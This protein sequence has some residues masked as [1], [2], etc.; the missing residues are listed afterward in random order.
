MA[1]TIIYYSVFPENDNIQKEPVFILKAYHKNNQYN[2]DTLWV[3]QNDST[4]FKKKEAMLHRP[5]ANPELSVQYELIN[6]KNGAYYLIYN[7][8]KQL[9]MEGIYSAQYTYEGQTYKQGNFY[10]AKRY[11]Y[12]KNGNIATI[13]YQEDGRNIKTE[14]FDSKKRLTKIKYF[15]KKSS[16]TEKIE[17]YKKGALKETRVYTGFSKYYTV[18]ANR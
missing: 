3:S 2:T 10:N 1:V 5:C 9:I 8:K 18:R 17:L 13:H 7:T 12:K 14:H 11:S 15:D 16:N 6:P 4:V